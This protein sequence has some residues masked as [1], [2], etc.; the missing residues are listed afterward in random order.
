[1]TDIDIDFADPAGALHGLRHVVAVTLQPDGRHSHLSGIYFQSIPTDPLD[2]MAAFDYHAASAHGYFKLDFLANTI[3]RGVRDETHLIT[4]LTTEPPWHRLNDPRVVDQL[5]HLRFDVVQKI[6]PQTI[7]ELAVCI[8]VI[9]PGKAHLIKRPRF[10]IMRDI[11]TPTAA[12]HYKKSHAIAYA[13]SI[14]VQFN[15]LVERDRLSTND[16]A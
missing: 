7:E 2:G 4:L 6:E 5:A 8:A 16:R 9:R 12:Y 1:M 3:Y 13:A 10:E 15:L 14:V 11:W